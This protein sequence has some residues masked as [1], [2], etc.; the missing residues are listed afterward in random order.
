[1]GERQ[2]REPQPF[3]LHFGPALV[4]DLARRISTVDPS[5]PATA[6]VEQVAPQL[7]PLE[8]KARVAVIA[9]GLRAHLPAHY[10][11]A[12]AVLLAI[13]GPPHS[14][15]EGMFT[16][17]WYLMPLAAFV[18][19]YGL[20]H[21]DASL[22]AMH[23]ITQRHTAEFTIR[24]FLVHYPD[25]TLAVLREWAHDPSF[26]VRRLVSEGTRPRLPWATRLPQF[27]AD[28]APV[29]ALLD[30]LK[31]DPSAYV[32]KSVAN[33]LNDIAK[34]HPGL[35]LATLA[36]WREEARAE[37]MW[38]IRH[39]LRTLV[40]Q[41][42][43]EALQLLGAEV[44]QVELLDLELT[45]AHIRVGS[46]VT[47]AV[48]LRSTAAIPQYLVVDYVVQMPGVRGEPR[49]KVFKL[50]SQSLAPGATLRLLKH[51]SFAPVA[52]RPVYPGV[53]RIAVQVNGVVLGEAMIDVVGAEG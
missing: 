39:A 42:H 10:P 4:A 36:R 8:L 30:V 16:D 11:A 43:P 26:H 9:A 13:L 23:A 27:I 14:E 41:G 3:K 24:P 31:D 48:T 45:P 49:V 46:T 25:Q 53:H 29:L 18:E 17:G 32:R 28:P 1:M 7:E 38:I 51:H 40:K 15:A 22:A 20:A 2:P 50:R 52:V 33:N 47:L 6:F 37:R 5:F 34:D 21:L 44:P 19:H 35:V 12:L